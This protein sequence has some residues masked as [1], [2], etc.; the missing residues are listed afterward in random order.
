MNHRFSTSTKYFQVPAF[1]VRIQVNWL[2]DKF[3]I[4]QL[5]A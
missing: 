4:A 1:I 3:S 5:K 2:L